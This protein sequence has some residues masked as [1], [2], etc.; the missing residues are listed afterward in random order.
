ME[1][2]NNL[3]KDLPF[4]KEKA[5]DL[6]EVDFLKLLSDR[7]GD[8]EIKYFANS[9]DSMENIMGWLRNQ[10]RIKIVAALEN[11]DANCLHLLGNEILMLQKILKQLQTLAVFFN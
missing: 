10:I 9:D 7:K 4:H 3:R 5:N 11:K 6:S 1:K 2:N 8:I